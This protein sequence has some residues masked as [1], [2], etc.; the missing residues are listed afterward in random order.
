[1][2]VTEKPTGAITLGAGFSSTDKVVLSAGVSQDNVFGSGTSL[3]VNVNTAKTYRTLTV[4]QVDP[5]FTIDGIKRITDV[6]Y[7]TYQPLFYS[8]D[9]SFKIVTVGARPEV[10]HSVL[11]SR[12]RCTSVPASSRTGWMSTRTRRRATW[13]TCTQFGRVSNNVPITV[14]WSRDDA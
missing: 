9:S 2:K 14:G 13:T 10:R 5:Y 8:T 12:T 1:M 6:Y 11:R 3:S 7:R 4:T